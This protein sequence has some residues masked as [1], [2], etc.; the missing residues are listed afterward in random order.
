MA[1]TGYPP[2]DL[3]DRRSFVEDNLASLRA[4]AEADPGIDLVVGYVDRNA[5]ATGKPL[6]NSAA[7]ISR[8]EVR[9]RVHKTLL[10]TYDVFDEARHFE[11]G[12]SS[13]P[14]EIAG[15]RL[16]VTICEDVWNMDG[17]LPRRLYDR[18]P[19]EE[20]AAAGV[21]CVV[22]LSA[23]PY[24]LGKELLR[25][26]MIA[27]HAERH[28]V[29]VLQTNL[30]GGN[31]ELIFDGNS[32]AAGPG[33]T[34]LGY[35]EAFEEDL[36][37]VD[38]DAPAPPPIAGLRSLAEEDAA[39]RALVL[40]VRDYL[41]K[42]GFRE[43]VIGLS[44]GIDSS[45]VACIA[46]DALGPER[47]LGV[48]MPAQ[49]SSPESLEDAEALASR[50]GIRF[51]VL[52]IAGVHDSFRDVLADT[53]RGLEEDIT[54][55]NLQSRIRGTLL[56]ALSNKFGSIVLSTGNKSEASVGYC[57][58][59]G[60][61]NGGLAVISD[62]PKTLCYRLARFLN[63]HAERIPDRVL[64]KPPSAELK[65]DQKDTD[66]LPPYEILDPILKGYVEDMRSVDDLVAEGFERDTVEEIVR[67]VHR[68][69]YKRRQAPP[70]IRITSKA[71]G[72]GRR[73]PIVSR[74]RR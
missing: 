55:E 34:A 26:R 36:V 7:V 18:N 49:V 60:D 45:L 28:G 39:H 37:L 73:I 51:L 54:E 20:L 53:F 74:Y 8:G 66:S 10:P 22:N 32:I 29:P 57:T 72:V 43:A 62:V 2:R 65:P 61:M 9:H 6:R 25:R 64:R 14:I 5:D 13:T 63:R 68:S 47:V 30:V 41:A 52:P 59:Y 19:I 58:L 4:V 67:M 69:E 50:L 70:G 16:G 38:L 48:A 17:F 15:I 35:G 40:G 31:D 46:A 3:L 42:T 56:M 21:D 1:I 44:G 33:G 23:S 71:F 24:S 12:T 11:P 27:Q